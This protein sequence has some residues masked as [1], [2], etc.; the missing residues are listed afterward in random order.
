MKNKQF[1]VLSVF[2]LLLGGCKKFLSESSQDLEYARNAAQLDELLVGDGYESKS[3]NYSQWS[4]MSY[5]Y[6]NDVYF[7]WLNMMDDDI[8]EFVSNAYIQDGRKD[9]FGFYTWQANPFVG[10]DYAQKDDYTWKQIYKHINAVNIIAQKALD[11]HDD[12]ESLK[13]IRGEALFLRAGFYFQMVNSYAKAYNKSTASTDPGVPL[14]TT[15]YVEDKFFSRSTVDSVY[16]QIVADLKEARSDLQGVKQST[17]YRADATAASLLLSRVYLFM[18]DWTDAVSAADE[19]IQSKGTLYDIAGYKPQTSFLSASSPEAIFTQGDN[20][21]NIAMLDNSPEAFQ[22][23]SELLALYDTSDLRLNT[24]FTIDNAGKRRYAKVF[25]S[26]SYG[27]TPDGIYSDNFFLRSSEAYLNKA[28]ALAMLGSDQ[29]ACDAINILRKARIKR[30]DYKPVQFTGQELSNFIMDERRRELCFEGFRW[31]DLK[32]YAVREKYP[33]TITI[34]HPYST[35]SYT[36]PPSLEATQ[37]LSPGDPAYLIP[38][39]D[40]A[41]VFNDGALEQNNPARPNRQF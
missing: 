9:F 39:P 15:E 7:P 19:V 32:R 28:E 8:T 4:A 34:R 17:I 20:T 14:K 37:V 13:R 33:F 35:V 18:Q 38:I 25:Y 29:Q 41:I 5:P 26:S 40:Y 21:I 31:F 23:S 10:P 16:Q 11:L 6:S 2:M 36:S 3:N 24:F 12:P 22:P 1:L 27:I 30:E